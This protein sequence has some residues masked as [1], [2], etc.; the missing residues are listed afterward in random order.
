MI[1]QRPLS[2]YLLVAALG[3]SF[4]YAGTLSTAQDLG[5][6]SLNGPTPLGDFVPPGETVAGS[7]GSANMAM[8]ADARPPRLT[9]ATT[10]TTASGGTF[11]G[12]W[13]APLVGTPTI[14]LTPIAANASI[15]CQLTSAPTSTTFAG[16]CWTAQTT[17]LNLTLIT[18]GL[19][20]NPM[21]NTA[22]GV[23]VQVIAIPPTQ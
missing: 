6:S 4:F 18:A 20:L 1:R 2:H 14:V 22:A 19:T 15:D 21:T 10:V 9:R 7:I 8:R 3:L 17:S 11:S 5:S 13:D 16:R 12:T 23:Q